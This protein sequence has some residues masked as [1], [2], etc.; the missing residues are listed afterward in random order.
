ME[1]KTP[2][3]L[4][5]GHLSEIRLKRLPAVIRREHLYLYL[6]INL[7]LGAFCVFPYSSFII[8]PNTSKFGMKT[9]LEVPLG[10]RLCLIKKVNISLKI[11]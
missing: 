9:L 6:Y 8:G 7:T 3:L 4:D 1:N 5:Y 11:L 10:V 2:L